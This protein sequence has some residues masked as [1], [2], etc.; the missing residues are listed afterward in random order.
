MPDDASIGDEGSLRWL[1]RSLA[2]G[3]LAGLRQNKLA[4]AL[5][6]VTLAV[7]LALA[8]D[9]RFDGLAEYQESILPRLIRL[10]TGFISSLKAAEN[11]SGDWRAYY[12]EN[13][14][15][16]VK[17]I[18]RAAKLS[19]PR[20]HVAKTKHREF[21]RYYELLDREF[22]NIDVQLASNPNIDYVQQLRSGMEALKPIRDTW[23]QWAEPKPAKY[24][25]SKP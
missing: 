17:D 23:A 12:F 19:R 9:S 5:G 7:L 18:L 21:I 24:I 4:A 25:V 13:A 6:F 2:Y 22:V 16:Q 3:T 11:G 10:E 8:L 14:H 15:R 20:A 1:I